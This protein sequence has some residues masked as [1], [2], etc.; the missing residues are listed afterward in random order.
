M[1]LRTPAGNPPRK[2]ENCNNFAKRKF[3][4]SKS[5][6]ALGIQYNDVMILRFLKL[7]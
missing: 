5:D 1:N 6:F 4:L 7:Y 2:A 3:V